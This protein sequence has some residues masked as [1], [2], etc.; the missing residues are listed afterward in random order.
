[1]YPRKVCLVS[2]FVD[3]LRSFVGIAALHYAVHVSNVKIVEYLAS[4]GASI[5]VRVSKKFFVLSY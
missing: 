1:M 3:Y 4:L 2:Y 5:D